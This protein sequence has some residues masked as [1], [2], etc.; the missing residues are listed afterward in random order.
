MISLLDSTI[1]SFAQRT[2]D[3]ICSIRIHVV[4]IRRNAHMRTALQLTELAKQ[5]KS[6][7]EDPEPRS[8]HSLCI[9]SLP[10]WVMVVFSEQS[11]SV[12]V[13]FLHGVLSSHSAPHP[14]EKTEVLSGAVSYR[15]LAQ[16]GLHLGRA[17]R[18]VC[19]WEEYFGVFTQPCFFD[20]ARQVAG[21]EGV[22][23]RRGPNLVGAKAVRRCC[24]SLWNKHQ[25]MR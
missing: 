7:G 25:L 6:R 17:W 19:S 9:F 22:Q 15:L 5:P 14:S 12:V 21:V 2:S 3:G 4:R 23:A 10:A 8:L 13:F 18:L 16:K 1:L 24:R 20:V 11:C